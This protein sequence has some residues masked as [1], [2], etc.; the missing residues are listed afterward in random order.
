MSAGYSIDDYTSAIQSL[1]PVGRVWPRASDSVITTLIRALAAAYQQND[2]DAIQ[3]LVDAFPATASA[4]LPEWEAT[5]GLPDDCACNT[6]NDEIIRRQT[7]VSKLIGTGGQSAAYFSSLLEAMGYGISIKQFRTAR[8]GLSVCGD[9]INGDRWPYVWEVTVTDAASNAACTLKLLLCRLE[10]FSPAHTKLMTSYDAIALYGIG[11]SLT[12]VD[13][14][15]SGILTGSACIDTADQDVTLIYT[16]P[17]GGTVT[18]RL[19][20][21][22]NGHFSTTPSVGDEF[23]VVARAQV[24]TPLCEWEN[25]ESGEVATNLFFDGAV[26]YSGQHTYRG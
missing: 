26:T 13:G 7:V 8:C 5:L 21:D 10:E 6:S 16:L 17:G 3:L 19:V 22:A 2:A 14:I 24:L 9:A 20:T 23:T 4:L 1:F 25:V 15:L 18:E 12:Y 11:I